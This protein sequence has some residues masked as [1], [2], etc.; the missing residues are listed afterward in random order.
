M[1]LQHYV[2]IRYEYSDGTKE[3]EMYDL[4]TDPLELQNVAGDPAYGSEK[5]IL[6]SRMYALCNPPP[7]GTNLP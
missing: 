7:P 1:M 5:A 3:D 6:S 4:Q 2:L